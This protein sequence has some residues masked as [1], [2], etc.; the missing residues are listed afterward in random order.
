MSEA[1]LR[2]IP[3]T[4]ADEAR[5]TSMARWMYI[6]AGVSALAALINLALVA[7]GRTGAEPAGGMDLYINNNHVFGQLLGMALAGL[8]AAWLLQAARAFMAVAATDDADQV[9]V[10]QGLEQLRRVFLLKSVMIILA[11][12][13]FCFALVIMLSVGMIAALAN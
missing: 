1:P 13:V 3:F 8:M 11:V 6:S 5:V 7:T 12:A 2:R 9:N 4:P 10:V